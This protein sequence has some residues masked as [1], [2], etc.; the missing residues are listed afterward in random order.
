MSQTFVV[1]SR[2]PVSENQSEDDPNHPKNVA[3]N[4]AMVSAQAN[5]DTKYDIYPPPRVAG[6]VDYGTHNSWKTTKQIE[7]VTTIAAFIAI[8]VAFF[9][10]LK[11]QIFFIKLGAAVVLI[12][13]LNYIV[14]KI[15]KRTVYN[16]ESREA[17]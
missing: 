7:K 5:A 2:L 14:G 13:S 4:A 3:K 10:A 11:S 17:I 1:D 15:E 8:V 16:F 12:M 9:V 6:F